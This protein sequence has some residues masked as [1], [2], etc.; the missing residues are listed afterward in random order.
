[1]MERERE[2][3]ARESEREKERE[4]ERARKREKDGKNVRERGLRAE[5]PGHPSQ[6]WKT[7]RHVRQVA[8][9]MDGGQGCTGA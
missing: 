8:D 1:M 2:E 7:P 9:L 6:P 3:R 5:L 4:I